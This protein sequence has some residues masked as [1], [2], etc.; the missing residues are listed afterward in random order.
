MISQHDY[1]L[2]MVEHSGFVGFANALNP[3]YN[4]VNLNTIQDHIVRIY[5]REKQ[6][7]LNILAGIHG[8]VSL[9]LDLWTSDQPYS[10]QK[11]SLVSQFEVA[12][13]LLLRG[14]TIHSL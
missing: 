13:R 11:R 4:S 6:K 10:F 12:T 3:Q 9:S 14:G 2:H 1:P 5:L 7:I 8:R